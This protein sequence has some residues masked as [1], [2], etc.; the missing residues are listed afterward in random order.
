MNT[1]A[2][3][4]EL[5]ALAGTEQN[6]QLTRARPPE[7][8]KNG[9]VIAASPELVLLSQFQGFNPDGYAVILT[10]DITEVRSGEYERHW[11]RMFRGEKIP[12]AVGLPRQPPLENFSVLLTALA[13]WDENVVLQCEDAEEDI[14]DYYIGRVLGVDGDTVLFSNF[15]ALGHWDVEPDVIDLHDVTQVELRTPYM[16]TFSKYLDGPCPHV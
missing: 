7:P 8:L 6:V 2:V 14:Q 1:S 3:F 10:S 16:L 13:E 11:E 12:V 4:E 9:F 15:D 5:R